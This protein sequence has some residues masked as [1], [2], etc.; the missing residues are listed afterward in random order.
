[1]SFEHIAERFGHA[2]AK[3]LA[4][5]LDAATALY[6]LNDKSP[7]RKV[8]QIDNRGGHFY[9]GLY[10]AQALAA[11]NDPTLAKVFGPVAEALSSQEATINAELLGAQGK[12]VDIGGYYH[13]DDAKAFAA[14]RPS[15]TLN[16]I[17]DGLAASA[18]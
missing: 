13:P 4:D 11:S 6:L 9:V 1:M 18:T 2:G 7:A 16:A 15:P 12:A 5:T 8:G 10:W 14:L 17:I 3:V